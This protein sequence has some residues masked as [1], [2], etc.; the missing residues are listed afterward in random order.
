E[1]VESPSLEVFKSRVDIA[2]RDLVEL[3]TANVRLKK[4]N[5]ANNKTEK[6][7]PTTSMNSK[8]TTLK[9]SSGLLTPTAFN[10]EYPKDEKGL[11]NTL[12]IDC[13]STTDISFSI[14]FL[15]LLTAS[16]GQTGKIV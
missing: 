9:E 15:S 7:N 1:V 11:R 4:N 14:L 13:I 6:K 2:L 3:G 12:G 16:R 5:G 10:P 8:A